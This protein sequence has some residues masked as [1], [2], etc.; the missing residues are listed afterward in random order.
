MRQESVYW[1]VRFQIALLGPVVHSW[2]DECREN[3]LVENRPE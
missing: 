3:F 1:V 2:S